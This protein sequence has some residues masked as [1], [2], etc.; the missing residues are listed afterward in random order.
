MNPGNMSA[1]KH[2]AL[3]PGIGDDGRGDRWVFRRRPKNRSR[4]PL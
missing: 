2:L 3:V 4:T 1:V